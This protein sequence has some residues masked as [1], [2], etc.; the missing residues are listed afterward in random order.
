MYSS[1]PTDSVRLAGRRA[2]KVRGKREERELAYRLAAISAL[3]ALL[4]A[5]VGGVTSYCCTRQ[6][7]DAQ[8]DL[9]RTDFLRT[10]QRAA[11]SRFLSADGNLYTAE[12]E[13]VRSRSLP[14][15]EG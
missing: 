11:Y 5:V 10:E 3:A 2:R 15:S 14:L 8:A 1:G 12:V 4:G 7:L 9:S 13:Y 6:Q